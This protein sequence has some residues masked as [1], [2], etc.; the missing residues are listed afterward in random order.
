MLDDVRVPLELVD[1]I[2]GI[3]HP[4]HR[5]EALRS[6]ILIAAPPGWEVVRASSIRTLFAL[7]S[8]SSELVLGHRQPTPPPEPSD[9]PSLLEELAST[10]LGH[11]EVISPL[12]RD[13]DGFERLVGS[14]VMVRFESTTTEAQALSIVADFGGEVL[15][16]EFASLARLYLI[17]FPELRSGIEILDFANELAVLP[18]VD[19]AEPDFATFG[20]APAS[21]CLA[22]TTCEPDEDVGGSEEPVVAAPVLGGAAR[23][24]LVGL[25]AAAGAW[26]VAKRR[27]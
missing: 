15:E 7:P 4:A 23:A 10:V 5:A 20:A 17:T 12:L 26:L 25:L 27:G 21:D 9:L 19:W 3:E 8:A 11:G 16:S 24:L 22:P 2:F 14:R 6:E 1:G 13:P 18:E